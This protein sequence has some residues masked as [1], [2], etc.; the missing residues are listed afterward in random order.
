MYLK[1][2]KTYIYTYSVA[3]S[4]SNPNYRVILVANLLDV[5]HKTLVF[6]HLFSS[7]HQSHTLQNYNEISAR[8]SI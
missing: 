5:M 2:F 1:R 8:N 3:V 6:C 7:T 4:Y